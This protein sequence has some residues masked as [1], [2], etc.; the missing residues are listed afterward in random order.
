MRGLPGL[1]AL[2]LADSVPRIGMENDSDDRARNEDACDEQERKK[3]THFREIDL[4]ISFDA[5]VLGL[6][7]TSRGADPVPARLT[8]SLAQPESSSGGLHRR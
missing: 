7:S 5:S 2:A 6:E 3:C 4:D 8:R 1:G